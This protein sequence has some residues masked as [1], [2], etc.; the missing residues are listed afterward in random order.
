MADVLPFSRASSPD[1][2]ARQWIIRIDRAKLSADEHT[3]LHAWLAQDP[4][5]GELLDQHAKLW[6]AA[7]KARVQASAAGAQA[8]N[9]PYWKYRGAAA[10]GVAASV[11]ALAIWF[12][13][14]NAGRDPSPVLQTA[15]GQH[16][17]FAMSDGSQI[18]LN[19]KSRAIVH[20]QPLQRQ[21][22]LVDGEGYF[23][24][25]KD[26]RRPFTVVAGATT[27][28]AVG[29]RFSVRR[30][31]N[32]DVDVVV[33]E[34]IVQV[35]QGDSKGKADAAPFA[36]AA[37]L[38]AGQ[39]LA[40]NPASFAIVPVTSEKMSQLLAWQ[41]GRVT[42]DETPLSFALEEMSRY[43]ATPMT[44]GDARAASI[45]ISGS[46]STNNVDAFLRTL[47]LGFGLKIQRRPDGQVVVVASRT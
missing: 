35:S 21:I 36:R 5:H 41:H 33:S 31:A 24:V 23:E 17:R 37:R 28:R 43:A 22:V 39:S 2:Q 7:G 1:E 16:Q 29:T 4:R 18:E 19:T 12:G 40:A 11:A 6:H 38:V 46:F 30:R 32:G 25:A 26:E 3:E 44:P 13:P 27:V 45:K 10:G 8:A 42:F 14:F 20:Y 15:A 47:E 9:R 34:G